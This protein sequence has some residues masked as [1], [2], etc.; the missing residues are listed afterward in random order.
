MSLLDTMTEEELEVLI[1]AK[2][3]NEKLFLA[4]Q[5]G[6]EHEQRLHTMWESSAKGLKEQLDGAKEN[7][8]VQLQTMRRMEQ[9]MQEQAKAFRIITK[10]SSLFIG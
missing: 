6:F 2:E 5:K 10:A 8:K 9:V 7:I 3:H 4:A 1:A